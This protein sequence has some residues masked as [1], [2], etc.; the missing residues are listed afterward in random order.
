MLGGILILDS[1]SLPF[2]KKYFNQQVFPGLAGTREDPQSLLRTLFEIVNQNLLS[3]LLG[4]LLVKERKRIFDDLWKEKERRNNFL[5]LIFTAMSASLPLMVSPKQRPFYLV[6]SIFFY[7]L[8]FALLFQ[9]GV[10]RRQ[11]SMDLKPHINVKIQ[12]ILLVLTFCICVFIFKNWGRV[13]SD[14]EIIEVT[15]YV[16][17]NFDVG[18]MVGMLPSPD[19]GLISYLQRYHKITTDINTPLSPNILIAPKSYIPQDQYII[20]F[21]NKAWSVFKK[22]MSGL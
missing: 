1:D 2:F 13:R 3:F 15:K 8:S 21:S 18:D 4:L 6:P 22:Q 11:A 16:K 7:A 9:S 19:W 12:K 14:H 5:F 20:L 17:N 10:R